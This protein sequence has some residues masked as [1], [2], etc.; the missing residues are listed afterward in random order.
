MYLRK[1]D[2]PR[3]VTLPDGT[4]MTRADLPPADTVRW[5]AS[6]KAAVVRAVAAG[7]ISRETALKT[8]A[9]SELPAAGPVVDQV[10]AAVAVWPVPVEVIDPAD[11]PGGARKRAAFRAADVALAASGT[12]SLE[13]AAAGTPMVI[14]Y[15]INWITRAIMA[16]MLIIDTVTLVNIVSETRVVPEFLGKECQPGPMAKAILSV[17]DA[18][19][20]QRAAMAVTMERLGA[21]GDPPGIRAARA[22]LMRLPGG[23]GGVRAEG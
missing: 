19:G 6:R 7:L 13:L 1:V 10:R 12:V 9:L 17:L 3:S 2:G 14:G 5:V 21:G 15:D 23:R 8:W 18:P 22:I 20:A 16:R 11:D 4:I